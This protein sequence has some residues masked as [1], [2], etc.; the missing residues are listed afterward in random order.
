MIYR[1][2]LPFFVTFHIR[3]YSIDFSSGREPR[4]RE[5]N[6][7]TNSQLYKYVSNSWNPQMA[8]KVLEIPLR[9]GMALKTSK[10]CTIFMVPSSS[11]NHN[12]TPK[13]LLN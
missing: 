12:S 6:S 10:N 4:H 3:K 7:C 1:T 5:N 11:L 8:K 13:N 9:L 2:I